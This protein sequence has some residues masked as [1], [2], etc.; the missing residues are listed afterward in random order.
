LSSWSDTT[1]YKLAGLRIISDLSLPSL[2]P[3]EDETSAGDEIVIRRAHVPTLLSSTNVK[4]PGGQCN[5]KELSLE[6]P[7]VAR[8][9]VREGKEI[10]VDQ[11][12]TASHGDVCA[13]LLG[14]VFGVLGHQRGIPPLHASAIDVPDGCV[15]FVGDSGTGK[16]TLVA[17]LA[18]TGHQVIADDVCF[19]QVSSEGGAQVWPGVNRLRLWEDAIVALGCNRA[20][21]EAVWRGWDKYFIPIPRPRN[22]T[23]PRHLRRVYQLHAASDGDG[24]GV[25][26]L[27][28]AA[29]VEVLIHNIYRLD[30]AEY[31]GFKRA[32]FNVCAAVARHVQVFR[33]SRPMGLQALRE[34]VEFLEDHLRRAAS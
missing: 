5:A 31:M 10:L 7:E 6:I 8:Y 20:G 16:S 23:A 30:L 26:R 22:P 33:F 12:R 19:L 25:I 11:A 34:G 27:N 32:A 2:Q 4:F 3:C 18:A 14:S 13:Y 24:A 15:A 1:A 17:A 28:G 9:L 29:A 21:A